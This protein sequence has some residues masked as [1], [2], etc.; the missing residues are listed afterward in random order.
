MLYSTISDK[1]KQSFA[2][3][4]VHGLLLLLLFL[5]MIQA[6]GQETDT[7]SI[8]KENV[9]IATQLI[10]TQTTGTLPKGGFEFKI[11]HRFG[12]IGTDESIYQQFLGFDLPANIRLALLFPFSDR[13]YIG[14]GRTKV[15]KTIDLES[16]YL[17]LQQTKDNRMP[18]SMALYGNF[19]TRTEPFPDEP[20]NSFFF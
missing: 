10:N 6:V 5:S 19:M 15:D 11:Q 18:I 7:E 9:F 3:H 13:W 12:V 2:W 20:P 1:M 16:K 4:K 14:L 8:Y 17:L